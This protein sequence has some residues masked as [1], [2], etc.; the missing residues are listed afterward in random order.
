[1]LNILQQKRLKL[2]YENYLFEKYFITKQSLSNILF[3]IQKC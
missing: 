1:M 2:I 3:T